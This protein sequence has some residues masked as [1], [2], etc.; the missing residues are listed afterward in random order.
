[1]ISAILETF[2]TKPSVDFR[3]PHM[4]IVNAEDADGSTPLHY[5]T[6]HGNF[7]AMKALLFR[8]ADPNKMNKSF[9]SSRDIARLMGLSAMTIAE[10][11]ISTQGNAQAHTESGLP[12]PRNPQMPTMPPFPPLP[13][14][15][16][17]AESRASSHSR[18]DCHSDGDWH[19]E[20]GNPVAYFESYGSAN[21]RPIYLG[22]LG[23]R[24]YLTSGG[25][26][27]YV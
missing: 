26:K 1:M 13:N 6:K 19:P 21:G 2:A 16:P 15:M 22:P 3:L 27:K 17:R 5:A 9:L 10:S 12:P 14:P 20:Y 23:G 25:N 18:S 7:Q 8:G 24:F 4:W 11:L